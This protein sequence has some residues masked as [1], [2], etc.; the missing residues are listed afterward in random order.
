MQLALVAAI[1]VGAVTL[2]VSGRLRIDL[3]ALLVLVTVALTGL[4]TAEEAIS[5]F[6]NPATVAVL[7]MLVL[8][9]GLTR[10]GAIAS[11][12]RLIDRVVGKR[13]WALV[14]GLMVTAAVLSSV[15][16][17]TAVVAI[18]LPVAVKLARDRGLPPSAVLIPLSFASIFGGTNTLIGTSTNL[19][20]SALAQQ[21]GLQGFSMFEFTPLGLILTLAGTLYLL[22]R[23]RSC[24]PRAAPGPSPSNTGSG[25]TWRSW[26]SAR[27]RS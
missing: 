26:R 7:A 25:S 17:D 20:V 19:L 18:L 8:A 10:T 16:N 1:S 13:R 15:A 21:Q 3:V 23:V 5:G 22:A 27:T 11:L 4:V 2:F 6:A 12:G 14:P 24:C 9:G